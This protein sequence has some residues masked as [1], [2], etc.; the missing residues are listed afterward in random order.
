MRATPIGH[1]PVE[2]RQRGGFPDAD[3]EPHD[4]QRSPNAQD[5][6]EKR[7]RDQGG[8]RR[9]ERP[10]DYG[11][12]QDRPGAPS[13]SQPASRYLKQGISQDECRKNLSHLDVGEPES[14]DHL[15]CRD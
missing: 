4:H 8:H 10:P 11:Q 15:P 2:I 7:R 14:R 13:V 12:G 3:Q 9:K 6:G 1:G 5:A